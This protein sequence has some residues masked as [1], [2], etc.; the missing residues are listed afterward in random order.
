MVAKAKVTPMVT[1]M[2]VPPQTKKPLTMTTNMMKQIS[3]VHP[4]EKTN[5]IKT[6]TI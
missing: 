1:V 6:T 2:T 3:Y 5:T 4:V